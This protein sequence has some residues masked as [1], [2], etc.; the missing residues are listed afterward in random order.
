MRTTHTCTLERWGLAPVENY[1]VKCFD[2]TPDFVLPS[3]GTLNQEACDI[4]NGINE[5]IRRS[6]KCNG[7]FREFLLDDRHKVLTR[8]DSNGL[9]MVIQDIRRLQREKH[10]RC[11][12]IAKLEQVPLSTLKNIRSALIGG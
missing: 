3:G 9:F 7:S 8:Y 10:G 6:I 5:S 1:T 2:I 4:Y 12:S 11:R